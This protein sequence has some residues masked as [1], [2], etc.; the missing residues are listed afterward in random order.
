MAAVHCRHTG[1]DIQIIT[2]YRKIEAELE[3]HVL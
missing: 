3:T 2:C 1:K